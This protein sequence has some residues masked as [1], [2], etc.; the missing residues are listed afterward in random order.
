MM[1]NGFHFMLKAYSVFEMKAKV[2]FQIYDVRDWAANN[3][4][5]HIAQ[6]LKK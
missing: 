3:Y 5:I 6:Y 1:K 4:N 2:N